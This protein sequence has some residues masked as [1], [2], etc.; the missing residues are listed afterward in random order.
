M[1]PWTQKAKTCPALARKS[2]AF[3]CLARFWNVWQLFEWKRPWINNWIFP[4]AQK[5]VNPAKFQ[6]ISLSCAGPLHGP[7][8][9]HTDTSEAL[10]FL[11]LI[12][13]K[14]STATPDPNSARTMSKAS[15][16]IQQSVRK[17]V[18]LPDLVNLLDEKIRLISVSTSLWDILDAE[19][20]L[21][22]STLGWI[23][24]W[25]SRGVVLA[26][27]VVFER[28]LPASQQW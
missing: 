22:S 6:L 1:L 14:H 17:N 24:P 10:H 13:C 21:W 7:R 9:L 8:P 15:S 4:E 25:K 12:L 20:L 23:P 26:C 5:P 3:F 2:G 18:V 11:E 19:Q 27:T 16:Q 28:K